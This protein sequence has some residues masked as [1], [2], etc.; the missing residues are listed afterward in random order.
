MLA[1]SFFVYI[2]RSSDGSL[3]VGHTTDVHERVKAHNDGRG[4][5]WTACSRPVTLVYRE[6][7]HD[8]SGSD[9]ARTSDQT[10]SRKASA[11]PGDYAP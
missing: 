6:P 4:A 5:T 11:G 1:G 8:Q 7:L 10:F 9:Y 3:Y 2:T